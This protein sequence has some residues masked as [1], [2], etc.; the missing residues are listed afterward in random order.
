MELFMAL[1]GTLV[2]PLEL[3]VRSGVMY[4]AN[5]TEFIGTFIGTNT[6]TILGG[7]GGMLM[8]YNYSSDEPISI[9]GDFDTGITV[10]IELWVDGVLQT[11]ISNICN[12]VDATG[13]Y[14][15]ST[16]NIPVLRE[17]N[18]QYHW[19][20]SSNLGDTVEGDFLLKNAENT[21][22]GHP[23]DRGSYILKI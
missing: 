6:V 11:I 14:T 22:G 7:G 20:M 16:A 23:R 21:D 12:E 3:D 18:V 10:T 17:G 4:G 8:E 13:K 1:S 2:L 9:I 19:R 15:W 5:G